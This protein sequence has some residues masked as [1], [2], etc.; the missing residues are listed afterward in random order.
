[1]R[2]ET[3]CLSY[4]QFLSQVDKPDPISDNERRSKKRKFREAL[5]APLGVREE[6]TL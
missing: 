2:R 3:P 6:P 4:M 1:M 5:T